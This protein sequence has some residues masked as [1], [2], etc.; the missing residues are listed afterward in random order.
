M[1]R[2]GFVIGPALALAL[3]LGVRLTYAGGVPAFRSVKLRASG[4][5]M[6]ILP[7]DLD[8]DGRRDLVLVSGRRLLAFRQRADGTFPEWADAVAEAPRD[9]VCADL[10]EASG[11]P[12]ALALLDRKGVSSLG[13]GPEGF[14]PKPVRV[15]EEPTPFRAPP[16]AP[17]LVRPFARDLTG[18]GLPDLL[19]PVVDGFRLHA[20]RPDGTF[21]LAATLPA[22]P[23]TRV[24]LLDPGPGSAILASFFHPLVVPGDSDG[25]GRSDLLV[26]EEG[27]VA[28]F[29]RSAD[30]TF[31]PRPDVVL[32]L[33]TIPRTKRPAFRAQ[34]PVEIADVTGDAIVDFVQ[35]L[36]GEGTVLVWAG[37]AGRREFGTPDALIKTDGY[38]LGALPRD[39]DGD[40]RRDLLVGAVDKIGI[41]GALQI[42]VSKSLTVHSL[43]YRNAGDGRFPAEPSH[44]RDVTVPLAFSTTNEGFQ[45]GTTAMA[46]W[47]GDYDG[48]GRRDLLLRSGADALAIHLGL[49][50]GGY[51]EAP[52]R[53][54]GIPPLEGFRF[55][56]PRIEEL[57][58]DGRSDLLLHYRD[59]EDQAD[60]VVV[61]LT[62]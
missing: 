9:A 27:R 51:P 29:R 17:L 55:V 1:R 40:G 36:P 8:R 10:L 6:G 24:A 7:A 41:L 43:F 53:I 44:R 59:W 61:L 62:K 31:L 32:D 25:D 16:G 45:V 4:K 18:D 19:V 54:V 52:D 20:R 23:A 48:D 57:N 47:D 39:L 12:A 60:Q 38:A 5:V 26:R 35:A 42:F 46:S 11:A 56:L 49:E 50:G 15:V 37:R 34:F 13:V 28:I 22:D 2:P 21:A 58:G 30:G 33:S 3:V 14:A